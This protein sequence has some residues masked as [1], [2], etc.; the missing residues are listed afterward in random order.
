MLL[1]PDIQL[2]MLSAR[3]GYGYMYGDSIVIEIGMSKWVLVSKS[4]ITNDIFTLF[5]SISKNINRLNEGA[6]KKVTHH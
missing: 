5:F 2:S 6:V 1:M 3:R 4:K